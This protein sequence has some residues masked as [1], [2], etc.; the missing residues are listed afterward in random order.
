MEN[1]I[2]VKSFEIVSFEKLPQTS[3]KVSNEVLKRPGFEFREKVETIVNKLSVKQGIFISVEDFKKDYPVKNK[4][5]FAFLYR[6]FYS[7]I[8]NVANNLVAKNKKNNFEINYKVRT[9]FNENKEV[10]GIN[11]IRIL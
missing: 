2:L 9:I 1:Q 6:S 10:I 3:K 7:V 11:I 8:K 5:D 4:E